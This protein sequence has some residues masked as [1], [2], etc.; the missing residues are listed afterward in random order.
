MK[1]I[2][3]FAFLLV[4][5]AFAA[6][7]EWAG[8][9]KNTAVN[10]FLAPAQDLIVVVDSKPRGGAT[11]VQVRFTVN[12][13]EEQAC[14]LEHHG[15]AN[16]DTHD[17]WQANLGR[18]PEGA[19]VEYSLQVAGA[20]QSF[21]LND[22]VTVRNAAASIRWLGNLHT[23]PEPD[24][25][26]P[27]DELSVFSEMQPP[28]VA[29]AAEAGV[30]TNNGSTWKTVPMARADSTADR[31]LWTANLGGFPEG[32]VIRLY[33]RAQNAA[34]DSFWDS[35]GGADYRLRVNSP[36]RDVYPDKGRYDPGET[37]RIRI[38]LN[39]PGPSTNG[40]LNLRI[41]HL[42]QVVA[43]M[44]RNVRLPRGRAQALIFPW[45]TLPDDFRG[46]GVDVDLSVGGRLRD[47]RS[48]ALDVSSDWTRFPR[49]GFFCD[50]PEND[51]TQGK[52]A[53]L[54]RFHLNAVQFY[55][56]KWTHDH[57]V[58]RD[59]NGRPA[60]IF[61]QVGGRVQSFQT[62][63]DKIAA[64]HARNIAA[65]SYNL[66]YGD[67]GGDKPEHV[68]WTAFT[69]PN[70]TRLEDI[71]RHDAGNYQIWV[72]DVSNPDWKRHIFGQFLEAM[73]QA[74]F[75]GIHLDNLGGE[76]CYK[77][78]SDVGIPEQAEFPRFINQ[79]RAHLRR[80]RP[81]AVVV[82]NDVKSDYLPEI[83][84]SDADFYYAE[85]WTRDTYQGI[86][87]NIREVRAASPVK[88]VVLAAY[89]NRKPWD[90][91]GDPSQ[92]P[93]PTYINDASAR[94]MAAGVFALGAFRIELGE[95][96]QMLVNEYFPLRA[97]RMH[98]GLKRAMRDY[99][100]FAVRYE[101]LLFPAP[102][103][104]LREA[105]GD[106]RI[107]SPTH[108]LRPHGAAGAIWPVLHECADGILALNLINLNG[109]DD[110]WRNP[111]ANPEP[112]TNF[113]LRV[114]TA[115]P[116]KSVWLAT[117]DDGLGRP[118]PLSFR[119]LVD[120]ASPLVIFT[121]PRLEYWNLVILVPEAQNDMTPGR[122]SRKGKI[123]PSS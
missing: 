110:Q 69:V 26:D 79:A 71:R 99:Y 114:R 49:Y 80:T 65:M 1:S 91:M 82:H 34:G 55:D 106:W 117:P 75:D 10:G 120:A 16:Y 46:Y 31:D 111:C 52:A 29:V 104:P 48:S 53:E 32:A 78:N 76:W 6:D 103:A 101:N 24:A 68:E 96:G 4:V 23:D 97:P 18:F 7:L 45:P 25:L 95:D 109:V 83:V 27:G 47:S 30:S 93:L 88:P 54:A 41:R 61:T 84:R 72:M 35:N 43:T 102:G 118:R 13:G 98:A 36:I 123:R 89:I 64:L 63:K 86:R 57:L 77:Y 22:T 21:L 90:E 60:N 87:D 115:G 12:D 122:G 42:D 58:P 94:L 40:V 92:P 28:G 5:P 33:V 8:W 105:T 15:T 116:V 74:G 73:E 66:M 11:N 17:R 3:A 62:V 19:V 85:V 81:G 20:G 39:H 112:Q 59:A 38:D 113:V 44:Q 37:A 119:C 121:V 56:W 14:A 2:L 9:A 50:F 108:R 70:S 67:S 107:D 100:S 51:D